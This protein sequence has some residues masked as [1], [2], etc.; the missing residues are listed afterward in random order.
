MPDNVY[1][2]SAYMCM[3]VCC[4]VQENHSFLSMPLNSLPVAVLKI[5]KES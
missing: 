2:V 5:V 1:V 4:F 3:F